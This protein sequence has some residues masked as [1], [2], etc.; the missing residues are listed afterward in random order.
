M[1]LGAG[2]GMMM[3]G[4]IQQSMRSGVSPLRPDTGKPGPV[5]TTPAAMAAAGAAA[6]P[7][8]GDLAPVTT[9][10]KAM[11]RAVAAAAGYTVAES[12][13]A[14]QVTVPVGPLR[15]QLVH[16]DFGRTD[17]AGHP[18]VAYWSICGP[19]AEHNAMT[20]LEYNTKLLHGAFAVKQLDGARLVVIQ[21]N[22]LAET[23]DQLEVSRV[24]SAVAWQADKVEQKLVGDDEN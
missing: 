6:G 10:P 5:Q 15:K 12:G 22:Q 2:F 14:W 4:M 16:V 20:L 8:F 21:A 23:L 11:I 24:L 9:D 3:P 19:A 7:D 1:G 13:D 18:I 17:D